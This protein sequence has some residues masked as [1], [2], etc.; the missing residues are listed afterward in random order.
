[1][2][3]IWRPEGLLVLIEMPLA[4]TILICL[5]YFGGCVS[6]TA[7]PLTP[8]FAIGLRLPPGRQGRIS[9]RSAWRLANW[10]LACRGMLDNDARHIITLWL[11]YLYGRCQPHH[12]ASLLIKWVNLLHRLRAMHF[13]LFQEYAMPR[14]MNLAASAYHDMRL[15]LLAR[16]RVRFW[17][18]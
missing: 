3:S 2:H 14:H 13:V 15:P 4:C 17:L 12:S 7:W 11:W 18:F 1:M 5:H 9:L 6:I 10:Y 8:L 16:Q